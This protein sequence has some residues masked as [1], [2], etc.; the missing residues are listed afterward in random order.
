MMQGPKNIHTQAYVV[1]AK[2]AP[3][4]LQDV[5]LDEIQPNE[6][7]VEMKYTGIC[8]TVCPPIV[9]IFHSSH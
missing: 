1:E 9:C 2:G 5:I 3:F 7:L 4:K 6:V 8:H